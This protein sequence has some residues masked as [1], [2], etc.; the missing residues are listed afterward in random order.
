MRQTMRAIALACLI[1]T[2]MVFSGVTD[3]HGIGNIHSE[4]YIVDVIVVDLDCEENLTCVSRPSNIIEYFGADWCEPC[5]VLD[6]D[7]DELI[8][9]ETFVMRHHPSP[10]DLSYNTDSYQRF[11]RMYR[12]LFLPSL[13]H[14]GDGLLTGTSQAQDLGQVMSNSTTV[15]EGLSE[16]S[17]V[18]QTLT[19]N[20][21]V[22]G[23]VSVWRLG[24]VAHETEPYTHSDMVIGASH[25]N[26]TSG[27][28]NISHLLSI[29]GTGL[30]VMLETDGLRNLTVMS[31]T[32]AAGLDLIEYVDDGL[33]SSLD[34]TP[35]GTQALMATLVLL[36]LLA[37]ALMM[38]KN[39]VGTPKKHD[40][41]QE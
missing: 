37:P 12:L 8:D 34:S 33:R 16:V 25:F 31:E 29:N 35:S 40:D 5:K 20:T 7:L 1:G 11:N 27:Q 28:G 38:W 21:S 18:N 26:S 32:P 3:A 23:T 36:L 30:V 4:G 17:I 2:V 24:D 6:R 41:E 19:W 39:T 10:V 13:I 22:N 9:N 15:F 14:N